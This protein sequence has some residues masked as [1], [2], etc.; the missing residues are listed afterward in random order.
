[1]SE[2]YLADLKEMGSAHA[3]KVV[4]KIPLRSKDGAGMQ[5]YQDNEVERLRRLNCSGIVRLHPVARTRNAYQA[6]AAALPGNRWFMVMEYLA[7]GSLRELLEKRKALD[8]ALALPIALRL[9]ETLAYLAENNQVH[10]DIKPDNIMFR[11]PLTAG[12]EPEPVLIDFGIA[13]DIG[14]AGLEGGSLVWCAPERIRAQRGITPPEAAPLP[15]PSMDV[16]SLGLILYQMV[17]GQAPFQGRTSKSITSAILEGAPTEPRAVRPTISP[18]LNRLILAMLERDPARRPTAV[19]VATTLAAMP[20]ATKKTG[21]NP[22]SIP[23]KPVP[24]PHIPWRAIILGLLILVV[25]GEGAYLAT[26]TD[27]GQQGM[28]ALGRLFPDAAPAAAFP[29]QPP[30]GAPVA[31]EIV[32][33]DP[34]AA[35][36]PGGAIP[37][38]AEPTVAVNTVAPTPEVT[39]T[40]APLAK[41]TPG[42]DPAAGT[43]GASA[44]KKVATPVVARGVALL[45]PAEGHS[46][47]GRQVFAWQPDFTLGPGEAFEVIFYRANQDPYKDGF[48]VSP[49]V[50]GNSVEVDLT[51]V[52]D[53][54]TNPLG[55]GGYFWGVRLR[56][57]GNPV[58]AWGGRAISYTP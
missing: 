52:D 37:S 51:A 16:W 19:E 38:A 50:Q 36:E 30:D 55:P 35:T 11:R 56:R 34:P 15:H 58:S 9:A 17:T 46:G 14:Q 8:E 49:L 29:D 54:S 47:K 24:G 18:E 28:S 32:D 5:D 27:L 43:G 48:G 25:M 20:A 22:P 6:R 41:E 1:M 57:D 42:A 13:R 4:L 44:P 40:L 10:L 33:A 23:P 21:A 3:S 12:R 2:V 53:D 7:G 45:Q 31:T 26:R 39:S